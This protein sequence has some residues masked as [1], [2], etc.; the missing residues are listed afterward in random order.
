MFL[1][2]FTEFYAID[3]LSTSLYTDSKLFLDGY[4]KFQFYEGIGSSPMSQFQVPEWEL[5]NELDSIMKTSKL[6]I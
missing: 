2:Y 4:E 3:M 1:S 5:L 6:S